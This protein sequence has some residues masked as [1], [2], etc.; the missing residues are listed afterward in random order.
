MAPSDSNHSS[1]VHKS[2]STTSLSKHFQSTHLD[3]QDEISTNDFCNGFWGLKD[4]GYDVLTARLR[5]ASRT[6]DEVRGF[7]KERAAIEEDYSRKLLKLSKQPL[8]RDE[9]GSLR[10]A[11][12]TLRTET[13]SQA[14]AHQELTDAMRSDAEGPAVDFI[15]K[16]AGL[17]KNSQSTLERAYKL[18][19]SQEGYVSKAREKY[20]QECLRINS[21]TA[22]TS[23]SQGRELDKVASKLESAQRN[24]GANERDFGNFVKTLTVT[25]RQWENEWKG[26]CDQVQDLEEERTDFI[27]DIAW[28]YANAVSSVC[29]T[30]DEVPSFLSPP[31][32]SSDDAN[33]LRFYRHASDSELFSKLWNLTSSPRRSFE[34]MELGR[35]SLVRFDSCF[36][37]FRTNSPADPS[38]S[39]SADPPPFVSYAAGESDPSEPSYRIANF[40]RNSNRAA[41]PPQA[42]AQAQLQAPAAPAPPAP[43]PV[44]PELPSP[45]A[46]PLPVVEAAP[47]PPPSHFVQQEQQRSFQPPPFEAPLN[48]ASS[49][50]SQAPSSS[51]NGY[52]APAPAPPPQGFTPYASS[53]APP[54]PPSQQQQQPQRTSSTDPYASRNA[55]MS[56]SS[57]SNHAPNGSYNGGG[58][59]AA[60]DDDPIARALA[61]LAAKRLSRGGSFR[62]ARS[63]AV[64]SPTTSNMGE[65]RFSTQPIQEQ[66]SRS[67]R[68]SVVSNNSDIYSP[69]A[70]SSSNGGGGGG[71]FAPG[72]R[73]NPSL[74]PPMAGSTSAALA[75]SQAD[76]DRRSRRSIDYS[77]AAES[78]V[79]QHPSSRPNS[80]AQA[81]APSPAFMQPPVQPPSPLPVDAVLSRYQQAFPGETSAHSR[82]NSTSSRMSRTSQSGASGP[83][84]H[85]QG[86]GDSARSPSPARAGFV[87]IGAGGRSPSPQ[88]FS[89]P[90]R[91][92]SPAPDG[93]QWQQPPPRQPSPA[94]YQQQQ[95]QIPPRQPSPAPSSRSSH[96]PPR[97]PSP[98]PSQ[99]QSI[100]LSLGPD[101]SVAHDEMAETY[102]RQQQQQ[103]E[104]QRQQEQLRQ[105]QL[106]QQQL[107]QPQQATSS[108]PPHPQ[109]HQPP[110]A[111]SPAPSLGYGGYTAPPPPQGQYGYA[112]AAPPPSQYQGYQQPPPQQQQ[113]YP[114][115]GAAPAP[116]QAGYPPRQSSY[117]APDLYGQQQQQQQPIQRAASPAPRAPSPAPPPI[118]AAPA[119]VE[120]FTEEGKPVIFYVKALYDYTATIDE[121]FDFQAGDIIAVTTCSDDGWW[122]GALLVSAPFFPSLLL[123]FHFEGSE[124]T[125]Y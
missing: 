86:G 83:P 44:E 16:L 73:Q 32:F 81:R 106:Q 41:P 3:D 58:P 48:I 93:N 100:G 96:I 64:A 36:S 119:E 84:P 60:E 57:S 1:T 14:Q 63:G 77:Q 114:A 125:W 107:Y 76:F 7:W 22:Q 78:I 34:A 112:A 43:A 90:G 111:A 13:Q 110:Q 108:R 51:T 124:K 66:Q 117:G 95:Q 102:R 82:K 39:P 28:S 120:Q 24:I 4:E 122:N 56:P 99:R 85:Q 26:F 92:P 45:P 91:S 103:Q 6:V 67:R 68:Q 29:V 11:L 71:G 10:V 79:G 9:I 50:S 59:S 75:Q 47:P 104:Q 40:A 87:G 80:P 21:Y 23:L 54:P 12:D 98:A 115:Y 94:P 5:G 19:K 113:Q 55:A 46:T 2:I 30:D 72:H 89:P 97:Q 18:K 31:S 61:D 15:Q 33:L 20:H 37:S 105:Q 109:Q 52:S 65:G 88:P 8:G 101:G 123:C 38:I 121:E 42:Q 62:S 17:K 74:V 70:Q 49:S 35:R 53:M 69:P 25:T 27:K 116:Q 118:Q